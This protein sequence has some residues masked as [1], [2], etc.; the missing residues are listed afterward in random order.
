[1]PVA[2]G[3][4]GIV[5]AARALGSGKQ[6]RRV[7]VK[8]LLPALGFDPRFERMFASETSLLKKIRHP[9]VCAVLD[10]GK[11]AG[12]P[13]LVMEWLEG[14]SLATLLADA[15]A[16]LPY[17]VALRIAV[18]VAR[19]LEAAHELTDGAGTPLGIVHRDVSPQNIFVVADGSAKILDFGVAKIRATDQRLTQSGYL[20]GKVGY[21]SPEQVYC[22]E[23]DARTDVFALG[24]VLYEATTSQHPFAAA[25]QLGTLVNISS[26]EPAAL[27]RT[28]VPGYPDS[29]S[30]V[31]MTALDKDPS[32]RFPSMREFR[33]ALE[34]LSSALATDETVVR[35][36][37]RRISGHRRRERALAIASRLEKIATRSRAGRESSSV[38]APSAARRRRWFV[39]GSAL[40]ILCLL[41][42]APQAAETQKRDPPSLAQPRKPSP[43][44]VFEPPPA[45]RTAM[46][47]ATKSMPPAG[48]PRGRTLVGKKRRTPE[49]SDPL[50]YVLQTRE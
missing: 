5:W 31:L 38:R 45:E 3:G 19:G 12:A 37:L 33:A 27:P 6:G 22:E 36:Y 16:P 4:M 25:A 42:R 8:T 26:P 46:A 49:V 30:R 50:E 28:I 48:A 29:L 18:D 14:E 43:G 9:N 23:V 24:V 34:E 47:P 41:L 40:A 44:P 21:M 17:A 15:R 2:R 32:R 39:G 13:Y 7:A 10:S 11:D 35:P 20:K 1:L